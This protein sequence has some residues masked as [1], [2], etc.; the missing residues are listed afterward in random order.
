M[1]KIKSVLTIFLTLLFLNAC[2][3]IAEGL[4]GSKKKGSDEFLVQK[5]APLVLP[6]SFEELPEPQI[7]T[8][9]SK[10]LIE[11]NKLSIQKLIVETS[12][13]TSN[14]ENN[15]LNS[16]I[17]KLIIEKINKNKIKEEDFNNSLE[18]IIK[19]PKKK[20]F[21]QKLGARFSKE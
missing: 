4:G 20:N 18:K 19:K 21:F 3:S 7:K 2:S 6:S 8:E 15:E 16:S 1:K 9:E 13:K 14:T 12:I 5:K 17:E 10:S 11:K